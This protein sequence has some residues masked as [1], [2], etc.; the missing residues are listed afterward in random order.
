MAKV[1]GFS[2]V[3]EDGSVTAPSLSFNSRPGTGFYLLSASGGFGF[4]QD[5]V[6]IF[7]LGATGQ[8]TLVPTANQL[9][10]QPGGSG[11]QFTITATNPAASRTLTI[12]DSGGNTS[13]FMR[14]GSSTNDAASAGDVGEQLAT[15]VATGS[16]V[17]LS[18]GTAATI[19]T[20]SLTAGDWDVSGVVVFKPGAS[21]SI[22]IWAAAISGTTNAVPAI[23]GQPTSNEVLIQQAAAAFV[24]GAN[25]LCVSI[26]PMRVSLA[27]TTNVYL[28]AKSTFSVSTLAAYGSIR[29][30]RIR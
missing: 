12:P 7:S 5:A 29:A 15:N 14:K 3:I 9:I 2:P 10:I 18:T 24:P 1:A 27:S 22:T 26:P 19:I 4:A 16:A 6:N 23:I 25:D 20:Q 21:T 28:V 30:R 11:N 17:S 8:L 13:F